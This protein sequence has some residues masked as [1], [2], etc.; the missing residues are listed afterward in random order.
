MVKTMSFT[1]PIR[2]HRGARV[3]IVSSVSSVFASLAGLCGSL[4][5]LFPSIGGGLSLKD[6]GFAEGG[7][8]A[9]NPG[10]RLV[11]VRELSKT[12]L[13]EWLRRP[14]RYEG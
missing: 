5:G 3:K 9:L 10:C 6:L 11:N 7:L 1:G 4:D 14:L 8:L 13:R 12:T 2:N